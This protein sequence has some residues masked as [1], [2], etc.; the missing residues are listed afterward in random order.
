MPPRTCIFWK[1]AQNKDMNRKIG[2]FTAFM[3][4]FSAILMHYFGLLARSTQMKISY[5]D[6][7]QSCVYL[8]FDDGPSDRV[9]PKIL[10]TLKDE[11]V[12][13]TFFIVGKSAETRRPIVKRAFDEGHTIG[14]HSYTHDY[15]KIYA[16]PAALLSDIERCNALIEDITGVKSAVYRFPGGSFNLSGELVGAVTGAGYRYVDWNASVRD[17]EMANATAEDLLN[18]A[19][20]TS[21]DRNHVVLL[22]HDSTNK[23]STAAAL[24]DIIAYY[25]GAGYVFC[26][27]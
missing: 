5:A 14:V 9:T 13:A 19:K 11:G 23:T 26:T 16:S 27:F 12:K 6:S 21:A 25:R 17:A 3:I 22:C 4:I 10:D 7:Q 1:C 24:K 15:K 18:A 2:A 8:T 20:S